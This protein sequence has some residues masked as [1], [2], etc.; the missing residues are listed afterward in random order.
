MGTIIKFLQSVIDAI[1]KLSICITT[2]G[3]V[4]FS[5]IHLSNIIDLRGINQNPDSI[6]ASFVLVAVLNWILVLFIIGFLIGYGIKRI[7]IWSFVFS[8]FVSTC[9]LLLYYQFLYTLPSLI[10]LLAGLIIGMLLGQLFCVLCN[11][12]LGFA[13]NKVGR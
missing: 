8:L 5:A 2:G 7:A 1:R 11:L 10:N 3:L 13:C 12:L 6:I 4:G 9:M